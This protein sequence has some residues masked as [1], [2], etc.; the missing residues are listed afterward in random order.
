MVR[1]EGSKKVERPRDPFVVFA[2]LVYSLRFQDTS[3]RTYVLLLLEVF[4]R[5][6]RSFDEDQTTGVTKEYRSRYVR[7]AKSG[8]RPYYR[9]IVHAEK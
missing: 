7:S 4:A 6:Q 9:G 2:R 5:L 8:G 3:I 1:R